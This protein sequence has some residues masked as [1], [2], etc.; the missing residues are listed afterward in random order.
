MLKFDEEPDYTYLKDIFERQIV[1]LNFENNLIYDWSS[2]NSIIES[3][4]QKLLKQSEDKIRILT[5]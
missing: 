1:D 5:E 3:S 2:I 4:G